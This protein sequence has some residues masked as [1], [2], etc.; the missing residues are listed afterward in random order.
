MRKITIQLLQILNFI[1]SLS[2]VTCSIKIKLS[3][4]LLRDY[5]SSRFSSVSLVIT[6]PRIFILVRKYKVPVQKCLEYEQVSN[7]KIMIYLKYRENICY[8]QIKYI[9]IYMCL[10]I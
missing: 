4:T 2:E 5:F 10:N 9:Y 1:Q 6:R 8:T 3:V 7:V